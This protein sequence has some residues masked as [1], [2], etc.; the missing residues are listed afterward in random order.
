MQQS[1]IIFL[2]LFAVELIM[3]LSSPAQ[4]SPLHTRTLTMQGFARGDGLFDIEGHLVDTKPFDIPNVDRGGAIPAGDALHDMWVRLTID[5]EMVVR[6]AEAVTE[7]APFNYCQ[8]GPQTFRRLIGVRMGPG[9]NAKV[10]EFLGGTQGCTHI[11]E[12]LAQM[13]TT[14]F[15]SLYNHRREE[16][17]REPGK[18]PVILDTCYALASDGPVVEQHWP[19]FYQLKQQG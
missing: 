3:P 6:D 18:K 15:Q 8:G 7:W 10:K 12:M 16:A 2:L 17:N 1:T 9:W 11:T 19:Q 13:A 14:A 5:K 4:R